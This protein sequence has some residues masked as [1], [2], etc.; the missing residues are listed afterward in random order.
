M[1]PHENPIVIQWFKNAVGKSAQSTTAPPLRSFFKFF[2]VVETSSDCCNLAQGP[3]NR[4][5]QDRAQLGVKRCSRICF[6]VGTS[7][8]GLGR[9]LKPVGYEPN[10]NAALKPCRA[11]TSLSVVDKNAKFKRLL[12]LKKYRWTRE[13]LGLGLRQVHAKR[14]SSC[15]SCTKVGFHRAE[16]SGCNSGNGVF[17]E[18]GC[19]S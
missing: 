8:K 18:F 16:G 1:K 17:G 13:K 5:A 4:L 15:R 14:P 19:D 11:A 9:S 2:T 7:G 6:L 12:M 10:P 3:I